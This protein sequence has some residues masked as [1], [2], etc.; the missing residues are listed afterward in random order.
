MVERPRPKAA[1]FGLDHQP[2]LQV[3]EQA[4]AS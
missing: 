1:A 4:A 2:A 3:H